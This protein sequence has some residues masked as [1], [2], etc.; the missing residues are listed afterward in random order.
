[1]APVQSTL[2]SGLRQVFVGMGDMPMGLLLF[3]PRLSLSYTVV[4]AAMVCRGAARM[5]GT[6]SSY[7]PK[8]NMRILIVTDYMPPQTHGIAIRFRQYID[9]MRRAGH[10]VHVFCTNT[11]RETETSFDHPNLPA[12]TNPYNTRNKMAYTAGVKLAWYLSAKQW[13][14]VHVVCPSNICWAVLPV[15]AWRRIPC[16]VSHHVDMEYYIYEYV[17]L[18]VCADFG[19]ARLRPWRIMGTLLLS[20][21]PWIHAHAAV[22]HTCT[23]LGCCAVIDRSGGNTRYM[24]QWPPR[25]LE[26]CAFPPA[27][28]RP[29]PSAQ[30]V[31]VLLDHQVAMHAASPVQRSA[32]AYIPRCAHC[33]G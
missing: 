12:I 28:H 16:Y 26:P 21:P 10:E 1:M 6:T 3:V 33:G 27:Y 24:G 25:G 5:V 9:Y 20:H 2:L 14:I 32:D 15:V 17:K 22:L 18:K 8:A 11:V 30:V 4:G 19:C 23:P 7:V 13:D 29:W 31:H